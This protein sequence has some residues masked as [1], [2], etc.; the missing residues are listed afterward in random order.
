MSRN[1]ANGI[2]DDMDDDV[3]FIPQEI[4][5]IEIQDSDDENMATA[6]AAQNCPEPPVKTPAVESATI[7][8]PICFDNVSGK[9]VATTW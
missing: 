6:I 2:V 7:D 3:I 4:Q 1:V 9:A 8:C 5:T